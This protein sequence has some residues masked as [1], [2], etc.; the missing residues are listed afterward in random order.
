MFDNSNPVPLMVY[1][2][3]LGKHV[4]SEEMAANVDVPPPILDL[5]G[6]QIPDAYQGKSRCRW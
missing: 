6:V 2:P 4:D 1:D 5:A 3:R